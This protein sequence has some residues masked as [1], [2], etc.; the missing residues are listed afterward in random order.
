VT[1]SPPDPRARFSDRVEA[2][3]RSRP[4]YPPEL[5]P[6]LEKEAGLVPSHSVADIGSGTGLLSLL[7]LRFG[8]ETF[9]VEPNAK[10]RAAAESILGDEPAFHSVEG[11]A[12]ATTLPAES[13]DLAAAGQAFHWFDRE[14][15]RVELARIL[16][17]PRRVALVWN[18]RRTSGS[19]F[20]EG[21]EAL[22]RRHGTDYGAVDHKNLGDA[23]F[24]A[25]FRP[26]PWSVH[27][28]E[29]RQE[30]DREGL[31][32]RVRSSSYTPPPDDPR[33]AP[34]MEELDRLFDRTAEIGHVVMEYETKVFIGRVSPDS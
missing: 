17:P 29:N 15:T 12:E 16:R 31:R 34:M 14:R 26:G 13:I 4:G 7:F 8:N 18:D 27:T 1:A 32:Q 22:L 24:E 30:F 5:I 23:V 2:Y 11:S 10:M 3:V 28:L 20:S 19:A 6:V 21:Y 25:F 9:A 33:H